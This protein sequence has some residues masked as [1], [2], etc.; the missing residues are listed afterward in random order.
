MIDSKNSTTAL[1]VTSSSVNLER[2]PVLIATYL[3][4]EICVYYQVVPVDID[5]NFLVLGM[6]DPGT[7]RPSIMLGKCW[8]FLNWKFSLKD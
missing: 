3:P 4:V 1:A 5:K 6:V 7:W 8:R 2:L